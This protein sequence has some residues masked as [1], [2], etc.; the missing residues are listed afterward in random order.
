VRA[1][2]GEAT[3]KSTSTSVHSEIYSDK[4]TTTQPTTCRHAQHES[5]AGAQVGADFARL[6]LNGWNIHLG[7]M[8]G[9]VGSKINDDFLWTTSSVQVPFFGTYLTVSK[10]R[11]FADFMVRRDYYDF[12][13]NS[14]PAPHGF[15]LYNQHIGAQGIGISANAGYNFDAGNGWAIEP[16]AGFVYS[17][18]S[19]DR[20]VDPGSGPGIQSTVDTNNIESALGRLSLRVAKSVETSNVIWQP[21]VTA[22]V[23]HEFAGDVVSHTTTF[24]NMYFDN[25][26]KPIT[27]KDTT[28]TSR[29]GTYGQYSVGLSAQFVN[30]GL[31]GYVRGDYRNGENIEGWGANAGLRYSFAPET[32]ASVMPVKAAQPYSQPTSWTGF[33]VGGF[34]GAA[35]GRDDIG[36][37][38]D[39]LNSSSPWIAGGIGGIELGYNYQF[40]NKWVIG[41]EADIGAGNVHGGRPAGMDD[42]LD[43]LAWPTGAFSSAFYTA[44]TKSDWMGTVAGRL[45][46]TWNRTLLYAKGGIAFADSSTSVDCIFGPTGT[47]GGDF[48]RMCTSPSHQSYLASFRTPHSVRIGYTL[49]LGAEFD[50]GHNWSVKSEYDVLSFGRHNSNTDDGGTIITDKLWINQVK[51]GL[52]YKF[53]P[54]AQQ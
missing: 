14:P 32:V 18:T 15:D 16:S 31:V 21:F 33:Y 20:Y 5:F 12:N 1:L 39:G 23:V 19:V 37:V 17:N 10:G 47:S 8:A 42:G 51:V 2:G 44:S 3:T 13:F 34:A 29:V 52:N 11:F 43:S 25:N 38:R 49:G 36:Y 46:Y 7:G 53:G 48:P 50:L 35:F 28:T 45:G 27:E 24:P 9:Y 26:G 40:A 22:S 30:T 6:N 41:I 54:G 4:T